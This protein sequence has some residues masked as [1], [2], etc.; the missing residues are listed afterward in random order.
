MSETLLYSLTFVSYI[1]IHRFRGL[2]HAIEATETEFLN[3]KCN[4]LL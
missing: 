3:Y 4:R 2:R 1:V